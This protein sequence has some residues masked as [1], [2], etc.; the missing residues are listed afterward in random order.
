MPLSKRKG[1]KT[2]KVSEMKS[3]SGREYKTKRKEES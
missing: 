1:K 3:N 2:M